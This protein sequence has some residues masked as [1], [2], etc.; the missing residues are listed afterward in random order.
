M[1]EDFLDVTNHGNRSIAMFLMLLILGIG[2]FGYF[3][4]YQ[5]YH[6]S[7]NTVK[8]EI[9]SEVSTDVNDY[10]KKKVL[11]TSGYKLDVSKVDA[12][13]IGEYNYTVTYNKMTKKGKVK[14]QDTKPPVFETKDLT[15]VIGDTNFSKGDFLTK[16]EDASKPC[17]VSFKNENDI[18]KVNTVGE[19]DI[20]IYVSDAY[21]NKSEANV[22]LS[23]VDDESFV[24]DEEKDLEFA[25][26]E[27]EINIDDLKYYIKLDRALK[28]GSEDANEIKA[29]IAIGDISAII[30][31]DYPGYDIKNVE[32][33]NAYNKSGYIIGYIV[34][35][36]IS[37]GE[38]KVVYIERREINEENEE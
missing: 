7:L 10:L 31:S 15:I 8:L 38:D 30:E 2:A 22:K 17:I 25:S 1:D 34:R 33:I 23:V 24:S 19:Y 20:T 5:K 11:D 13:K 18:K 16:C 4:V 36:T 3:F 21:N 28:R 6:F 12:N 32:I 35:A 37:D 26:A 9:G 27:K 14:V 29:L